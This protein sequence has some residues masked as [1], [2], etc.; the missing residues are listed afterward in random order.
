MSFFT[1]NPISSFYRTQSLVR[2]RPFPRLNS[3]PDPTLT[4]TLNKTLESLELDSSQLE[5]D[6][7]TEDKKTKKSEPRLGIGRIDLLSDDRLPRVA[8]VGRPNVGKSA[9]L[10]R[11]SKSSSAIVFDKPGVTRDRLLVRAFWQRCEFM[12]IDTGGLANTRVVS[13]EQSQPPTQM[14]DEIPFG[15]ELQVAAAVHEADCIVFVVDGREGPTAGD[16]EILMWLKKSHSNKPV[17]MAVN[18][19]DNGST[20]DI[21]AAAFWELGIEPYPVSAISGLGT[22]D[23]LDQLVATLPSIRASVESEEDEVTSVAIIGRPNTGKSSLLNILVGK[24][25]SIVSRVA[26]TTR[27]AIDCRVRLP[28]GEFIKLIDTAGIRRRMAVYGSKEK[29]EPLM[30]N[31]SIRALSR[32][33]IAI[34]MIDCLEG[35]TLQDF[36]IVELVSKEGCGLVIIANKYDLL[37]PEDWDKQM[38]RAV[39][40]EQLRE[41]NWA[42][43]VVTSL[44]QKKKPIKAISKAIMEADANH[45]K[46]ISTATLNQIIQDAVH[47]R[48]PPASRQGKKGRIYYVNQPSTRPPTFVFFVNDDKLFDESYKKYLEKYLRDNIDLDGTSIKIFFRGKPERD[49]K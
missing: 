22:G 39:L 15:V 4:T 18:K 37:N 35:V 7:T 12:L 34:L 48:Q 28:R 44:I 31:H 3:H 47:F 24:D 1:V 11:L 33:N 27:D 6:P 38:V 16:S 25:R 40:K 49:S 13:N 14:D 5:Q 29:V 8:L 42:K 43:I 45:S 19:C 21:E 23:L 9:L 10:N 17:V 30:V 36:K 41:A 46:R 32:S 20:A 26:G 2:P